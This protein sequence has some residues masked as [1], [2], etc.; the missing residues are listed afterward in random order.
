MPAEP[1][2]LTTARLAFRT[3]RDDDE[4]LALALW[5]D[6]QVATFI[7]AHGPPPPAAIL[8]RLRREIATQT[9]HG[10]Q[11]WPIFLRENGAHAGCAG[12][13]PYRLEDGILELGIHL[14]PAFWH[15][16]L[17][18]EA[19]AAVIDYAFTRLGAADRASGAGVHASGA[20]VRT[21]FAGHHP[22]NDAS[23]RMLLRLGFHYTH[24]E[25][26]PP[27]GLEHPSY[28][29]TRDEGPPLPSLETKP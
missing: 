9:Q 16:G 13:R 8:E 19:G 5:G 22:K 10:L 21:L 1:Y 23:R 6:P 29:L 12:L 27:T 25:L 18:I 4:P 28:L 26:Y 2:F 24:D 17:A 15:R 3:W 20:G 11:Y 14:R 7:H